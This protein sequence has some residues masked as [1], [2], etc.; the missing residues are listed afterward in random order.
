MG[1]F[2]QIGLTVFKGGQT[3]FSQ[4]NLS[5]DPDKLEDSNF[6]CNLITAM[7]RFSKVTCTGCNL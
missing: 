7:R 2:A 1:Q 5:L 3:H 4:L 6:M